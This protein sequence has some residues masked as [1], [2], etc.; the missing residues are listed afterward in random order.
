[1]GWSRSP[2]AHLRNIKVSELRY[3]DAGRIITLH[4]YGK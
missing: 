2:D 1:V 4:P 3:D